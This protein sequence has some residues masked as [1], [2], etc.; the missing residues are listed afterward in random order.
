MPQAVVVEELAHW[1]AVHPLGG[2]I[3][4]QHLALLARYRP[5]HVVDRVEHCRELLG[6]VQLQHA[7][8]KTCVGVGQVIARLPQSFARPRKPHGSRPDGGLHVVEAGRHV[9]DLVTGEDAHRGHIHT[10]VSSIQVAPAQRV[11]RARQVGQGAC[12]QSFCGDRY[13]RNRVADHPGQHQCHG[14][15]QHGHG[16]EDV[17]Q[18]RHQRALLR[19]Q[20]ADRKQ[21]AG[22]VE[23]Q[24]EHHRAG[25]LEL[26]R[27]GD[28]GQAGAPSV[29]E[30]A[31]SVE[32]RPGVS[33]SQADE[34]R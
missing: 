22:T 2:S 21:I 9:A 26:H 31:P 4:V 10:R 17:G 12:G 11:H 8:L 16:D 27:A 32:R 28:A 7:L 29:I 33:E 34:H 30:F 15:R 19:W 20:V 5:D 24:H 13:L 14:D 18:P 23:Q 3:Q 1:P 25:Q 6:E